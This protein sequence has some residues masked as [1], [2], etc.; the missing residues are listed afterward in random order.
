MVNHKTKAYRSKTCPYRQNILWK[1]SLVKLLTNVIWLLFSNC[2][3]YWSSY[4]YLFQPKL[5]IILIN[6]PTT[7]FSTSPLK[8]SAKQGIKEDKANSKELIHFEPLKCKSE[9]TKQNINKLIYSN[10]PWNF[11]SEVITW[12]KQRYSW[13]FR[14]MPSSGSSRFG[15]QCSCTREEHLMTTK[16]SFNN[17]VKRKK[18]SRRRM[19]QKCIHTLHA[20]ASKGLQKGQE[21]KNHIQS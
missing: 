8:P 7:K 19:R 13:V 18:L 15:R 4:S 14:G 20:T 12:L 5:Q 16:R 10:N 9:R 2:P 11:F 1:V 17:Q 6:P 3:K 21:I